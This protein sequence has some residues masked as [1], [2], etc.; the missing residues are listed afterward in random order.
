MNLA[1]QLWRRGAVD[2]GG[3]VGVEAGVGVTS[4]LFEGRAFLAPL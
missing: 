3:T 2:S 1:K 4:L